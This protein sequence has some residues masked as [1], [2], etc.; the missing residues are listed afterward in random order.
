MESLSTLPIDLLLKL[1][2]PIGAVALL[3]FFW[4]RTA[5]MHA[6]MERLWRIAAGAAPSTDSRLKAFME[7]TRDLERFRFIYGLRIES[8]AD[9]HKL[10]AWREKHH[11]PI[12]HIRRM[13][14]WF[15]AQANNYI[16]PPTRAAIAG[17]LIALFVC[18]LFLALSALI[19]LPDQAVLKTKES[20]IWFM[21]SETAVE[22]FES[23]EPIVLSNCNEPGW[24]RLRKH[25]FTAYEEKFI[26]N[27][28]H[29]NSLKKFV[30]D[31]VKDQRI[32]SMV[33]QVFFLGLFLY[34]A[35][36][37]RASLQAYRL[38]QHIQKIKAEEANKSFAPG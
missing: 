24:D 18:F 22:F 16:V 13:H 30:D 31:T 12:S 4:I 8:S 11:I 6:I 5:T 20:K 34:C 29:D 37:T 14:H 26:C 36:F 23:K 33:L 10:L 38:P 17:A 15:D 28:A 7:E 9:L 19:G 2:V 25:G 32:A 35:L 3:I 1:A 27:A 21:S